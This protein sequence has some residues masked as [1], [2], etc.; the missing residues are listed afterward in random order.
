MILARLAELNIAIDMCEHSTPLSAYRML[1]N[2]IL[3]IASVHPNLAATNIVEHYC[4]YEFC[5][6][7]L[8]QLDAEYEQFE[9]VRRQTEVGGKG[10]QEMEQP[11]GD[12]PGN[13]DP[14]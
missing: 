9:T 3:P 7:C 13:G 8:A 2:E 4:A 6:Q 12:N 5:P 1:V 14:R 11:E 10:Q